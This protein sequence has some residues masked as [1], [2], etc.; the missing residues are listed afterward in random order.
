MMNKKD[1]H[2]ELMYILDLLSSKRTELLVPFLESDLNQWI[3]HSFKYENNQPAF[4]L[5]K[6]YYKT[7]WID[8]HFEQL[9]IDEQPE[10]VKKKALTILSE[11][12]QSKSFELDDALIKHGLLTAKLKTVN[13]LLKYE[14]ISTNQMNEF[15]YAC[16]KDKAL[17]EREFTRYEKEM[18]K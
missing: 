17:F 10:S 15:K 7:L 18:K 14:D 1:S 16:E 8:K 5:L 12:L 13:E 11:F 3:A 2:S 4:N 6:D 9:T